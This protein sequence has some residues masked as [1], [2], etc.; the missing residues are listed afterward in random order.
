MTT[1]YFFLAIIALGV[2][3]FIHELGHY[4]VAKLV[5]M[6]VETF[7]IGFGYPILKWKWNGVVWK[8]GCLPFG[9][10]VK[11]SGMEF[12]KK[13]KTDACDIYDIP[14]GFFSKSPMK[15]I[16]VAIAGPLANI[17]LAFLIFLLMWSL[18]GREKPFSEYTQI[19]GWVDPN[20]EIYKLGL[21]P[22]DIIT[23]YNG[24]TFTGAKDLIYAAMLEGNQVSISGYHVDYSSSK[25]I[26]FKHLIS[27]YQ[28]PFSTPGI[29][30]T[31][32][33]SG[34]RYLV[35]N[36]F[37]DNSPNKLPEGSPMENSGVEYGDRLIWAD[38]ELLFSMEQLSHLLNSQ[39]A[40][41]T[42]KR[43]NKIFLTREPRISIRDVILPSN[44]Q[45]DLI[46]W[47]YETNIPGRWQDLKILPYVINNEGHIES[48]M[49]FVDQDSFD[50]AF[51]LKAS[52]Q[53]K[54]L[55]PHDQILAVDG[56]PVKNGYEILKLVQ[57]H[58]VQI[59]V[60]RGVKINK[61]VSWK[62]G[63]R[64]FQDSLDYSDISHLA[65]SVGLSDAASQWKNLVLLK[66]IEPKPADKF[67]TREEIKQKVDGDGS[68]QKESSV[69]DKAKKIQTINL[70]DTS[71]RRLLLG[72]YLQ[73]ET[74][75]YNP[76]P[77]V[78]L[79]DVFNETWQTLRALILG[80]LNPKWVSGPVGIVRVLHHGW[81]LGLSEALFWIAAISV[82]LGVLNL[83]PIPILD[84]GYICLSIWEMVTH[85][86]IK[87]KTM[88]RLIVPFVILLIGL[89]IFLTFQDIRHLLFW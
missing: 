4:L 16:A 14:N 19:V 9:G 29:L 72:I 81:Q 22:G 30:T 62:N 26:P 32:I 21:R 58:H 33:T 51:S 89:L 48:V 65:S 27:P 66:P 8:L 84:G 44:I 80:Y 11:I 17:I 31:G 1:L 61:N 20:S 43:G 42:V 5:G 88:E 10:Y 37:S 34:A 13:D 87:S 6:N 47:Q 50:Q 79:S 70:L 40:L 60:E 18:G 67:V 36:R 76:S 57:K 55:E 25:K 82:N 73:D 74:V 7:S 86:K 63:D 53:E 39:H 59:M 64:V 35:Y 49:K 15:R 85:R 69:K 68:K 12:G 41:L 2:L 28:A 75:R 45:N 23:S 56:I 83:L 78:I 54:V 38:G 71:S 3:V 46:D 77:L 24:N 52:K